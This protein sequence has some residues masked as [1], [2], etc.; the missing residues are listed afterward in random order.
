M[1]GSGGKSVIEIRIYPNFIGIL[2]AL[3]AVYTRWV[4]ERYLQRG[5]F[6]W[7]VIG[8]KNDNIIDKDPVF[9][10]TNQL[11]DQVP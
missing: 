1:W 10:Y 4:T 2:Q 7:H 11:F 5:A 9:R 3:S 6:N 8:W